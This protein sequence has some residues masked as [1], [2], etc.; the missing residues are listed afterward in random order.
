MNVTNALLAAG[1]ID[2]ETGL[3]LVKKRGEL[4]SRAT[5]GSMAAVVNCS[6]ADIVEILRENGFTGIDIAN[7]NTPSQIVVSGV[8]DQVKQSVDVFEG[9]GITAI[10]LNVSGAFHSR[11]MQSSRE[12]FEA[13]LKDFDFSELHLTLIFNDFESFLGDQFL[14][15]SINDLP[16]INS[17]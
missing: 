9:A 1:G 17:G 14:A 4:M 8:A 7:Y 15:K 12:E 11:L 6:E 16:R 10:Q 2:F 3:Q 13:F 5:G